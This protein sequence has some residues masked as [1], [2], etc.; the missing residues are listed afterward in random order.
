MRFFNVRLRTYAQY[1]SMNEFT[2]SEHSVRIHRLNKR[3]TGSQPWDLRLFSSD[4][5]FLRTFTYVCS[6]RVNERVYVF[7]ALRTYTYC[8]SK[9]RS[10]GNQHYEK[11]N[12]PWTY[13][14]SSNFAM[15]P[16]EPSSL[17]RCT[18]HESLGNLSS[19]RHCFWYTSQHPSVSLLQNNQFQEISNVLPFNT[20]RRRGK[21]ADDAR[22]TVVT[23]YSYKSR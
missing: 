16:F 11:K 14:R 17:I 6:I 9:K 18:Q 2:C 23:Q 13:L 1:A 21:T 19:D 4:A 5:F 8:K 7:W 22:E 15:S 3:I 12:T 20:E 10:T